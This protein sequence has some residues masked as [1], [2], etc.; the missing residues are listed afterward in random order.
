M[1]DTLLGAIGRTPDRTDPGEGRSC[2]AIVSAHITKG[3][4][5][6]LGARR[7]VPQGDSDEH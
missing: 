5:A 3:E 4:V 1:Y 2:N 7:E 6:F